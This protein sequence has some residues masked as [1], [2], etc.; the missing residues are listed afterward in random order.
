MLRRDKKYLFL[1]NHA[2]VDGFVDAAAVELDGQLLFRREGF[3]ENRTPDRSHHSA[4]H[5]VVQ[6][7]VGHADVPSHVPRQKHLEI[8]I[9]KTYA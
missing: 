4:L 1:A 7:N 6:V 9:L 8:K 5:R 2:V 3:H